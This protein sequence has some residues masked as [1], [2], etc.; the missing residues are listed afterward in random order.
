MN[1]RQKLDYHYKAFDKSQISPDPLQF[2]HLFS[3]E[4][5]IELMGF[6]ASIFAYGNVKQIINTLDKILIITNSKPYDF[7][8]NFSKTQNKIK[9]KGLKHRFYTEEDIQNLFFSLKNIYGRKSSLKNLFFENFNKEEKNIKNGLSSFSKNFVDEIKKRTKA[10]KVSP[11]VRFM[12]PL[13]ELGS[14]CKRMNLFLRWM[15]RKDDLDFGLWNEI[16]PDKLVIPVDTHIARICKTLKLTTYRN[17]S[18]KMAEQITE[19]LK[20]FD[21]A[22]PI[23]YDFA[24][25]HIG[26]RKLEF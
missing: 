11:G 16:Y 9:L 24:I 19:N 25:C 2:L 8:T 17:L 5:D 13:P 12:F 10:K 7:V 23:K 18:W 26:M 6:I 14:A 1:L 3:K 22:D 4:E 15:V 21:P 20:V